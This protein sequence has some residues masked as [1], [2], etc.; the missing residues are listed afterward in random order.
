MNLSFIDIETTG[1]WATTDKI[2]EVGIIRV[3]NGRVKKR[4]NKLIDPDRPLP[5]FITQLTGISDKD[6]VSA[7]SFYDVSEEILELL[8]DSIFVA[9]N[10]GFDYSFIKHEFENI[11]HNFSSSRLCTVKLS[12]H[13]YPEHK[14]HNLDSVIQRHNLK[15]KNRHRAMD[16]AKAIFEFYKILEKEFSTEEISKLI[17][18]PLSHS[19]KLSYDTIYT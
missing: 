16:D 13:F 5:P 7:P 14:R 15:V 19:S 17:K 10:V 4:L 11:G 8:E 12:R 18:K 1:G 6:L 9:H 3:E 2:I